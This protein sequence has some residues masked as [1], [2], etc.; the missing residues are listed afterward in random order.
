[1]NELSA[2]QTKNATKKPHHPR[3]IVA[4]KWTA[5]QELTGP[6]IGYS[7][8]VAAKTLRIPRTT[9]QNWESCKVNED[10]LDR[11]FTSEI[12]VEILHRIICAADFVIQ[13]RECGSRSL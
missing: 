8:R 1:M 3:A 13:F 12:G 9:F 10:A 11:F 5:Y 4:R 6:E 2:S 7:R